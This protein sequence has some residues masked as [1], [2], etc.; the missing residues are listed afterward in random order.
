MGQSKIF[1]NYRRKDSEQYVFGLGLLLD[2][3]YPGQVF[4]DRDTL[5][6][7]MK[8]RTEIEHTLRECA[9]VVAVIGEQWSSMKDEAGTRRIDIPNDVLR[10]ELKIALERDIPVIP[11]LVG[12]AAMP[13]T[14]ELPEELHMLADWQ[15]MRL[16]LDDAKGS[17]ARL[18]A[19]IEGI[20]EERSNKEKAEREAEERLLQD[21]E[22]KKQR[23]ILEARQR[24]EAA[25]AALRLEQLEKQKAIRDAEEARRRQQAEEKQAR[26]QAEKER[27]EFER[28]RIAEIHDQEEKERKEKLF[29]EEA[30]R[31]KKKEEE[32][33]EKERKR[34]EK[35]NEGGEKKKTISPVWY[36]VGS[37]V[38]VIALG[39]VIYRSSNHSDAPPPEPP[40][41]K[42]NFTPQPKPVVVQPPVPV[43][44]PTPQTKTAAPPTISDEIFR[45]QTPPAG[46]KPAAGKPLVAPGSS[47]LEK[48]FPN[49]NIANVLHGSR[50]TVTKDVVTDNQTG[51]QWMS[52]DY[53]LAQGSFP[54]SWD[55]ASF[56]PVFE[57]ISKPGGYGDWRL[58][59]VP[60]CQTLVV[61]ADVRQAYKKAFPATRAVHFWT[62]SKNGADKAYA[63]G[64]NDGVFWSTT[65]FPAK[66]ATAYTI[67]VRLVRGTMKR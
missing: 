63:Y 16:S 41:A 52:Q 20:L 53:V 4:W 8:Y 11:V 58:P 48:I 13:D 66:G 62:A 67:S 1:L 26:E 59:T 12:N 2:Q 38:A 50:F 44:T 33:A 25:A 14:R 6:P 61:N 65:L 49:G 32:R 57:N 3:R 60:E 29:A 30:E 10:L 27:A 43:V 46:N 24:E 28:R 45:V 40:P 18:F 22:E 31:K 39:T 34:L 54:A 56:W 64:V 47:G 19:V 21:A 23:E 42:I 9:V 17:V 37:A 36:G 15:A 55:V 5:K 7:G 51:L 35:K